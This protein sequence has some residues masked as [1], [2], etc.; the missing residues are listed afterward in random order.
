MENYL[1]VHKLI[2]Q[3]DP[4]VMKSKLSLSKIPGAKFTNF[5]SKFSTL[6]VTFKSK[7]LTSLIMDKTCFEK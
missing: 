1:F 7:S 5:L 6:F 2:R 4:K 3:S